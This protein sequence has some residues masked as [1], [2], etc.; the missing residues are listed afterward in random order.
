MEKVHKTHRDL[1]LW[2]NSIQLVKYIYDLSSSFPSNELYGL[3]SQLRRAAVSVPSNIAE[4]SARHSKKEFVQ[5][6][7]IASGSMSEIETQLIISNELNYISVTE[8]EKLINQLNE[9]RAQLYGL[10]KYLNK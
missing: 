10:I 5:F 3:T 8:L 2:K 4:G 9:L 6:L 1:D 7:Y